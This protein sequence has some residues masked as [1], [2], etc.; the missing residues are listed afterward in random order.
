MS[1]IEKIGLI[2]QI[3][4]RRTPDGPAKFAIVAGERRLESHMRLGRSTIRAD[5]WEA[6]ADEAAQP[7][8][9]QRHAE[10]M[11][12]ESNVQVEPLHLFEEG[13]RYLKWITEYGMSEDDIAE[14]LSVPLQRVR[15]AIQP[16]RVIPES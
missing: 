10:V 11:T 9:F 14:A 1:S 13:R 5:I 12:V 7:E 15:E 2:H 4:L 6:S 8:L 16:V 3:V